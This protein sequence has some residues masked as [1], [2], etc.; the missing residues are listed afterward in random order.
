MYF[1]QKPSCLIKHSTRTLPTIRPIFRPISCR[2]KI[3]L[4]DSV[5]LV[6]DGVI[7]FTMFYCGLNYMYYRDIRLKDEQNDKK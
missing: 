6:S 3:S 7:F 2:P 4:T 5:H 1:H